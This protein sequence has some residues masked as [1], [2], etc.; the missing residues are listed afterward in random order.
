AGMGLLLLG[1]VV[2]VVGVGG[3]LVVVL[4]GLVLV[5]T[6]GGLAL[7]PTTSVAMTSVPPERA[8]MA[9]GIMSA[10]RALGSTAGFAIMGSI[11][12][13]VVGA[14]LPAK[15]E[16][17]IPDPTQRQEAVT[18]IVDAANPRAVV[19]LIGP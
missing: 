2:I 11:L 8:G 9:S 3:A 10:Q 14:T 4:L 13:V 18:D 5:G 1:L 16:S 19:G 7:A 15:L 6:A 17:V 12:A